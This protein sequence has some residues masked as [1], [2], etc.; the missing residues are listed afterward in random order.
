MIC[1]E[2][3]KCGQL[4]LAQGEAVGGY[5]YNAAYAVLD[6]PSRGSPGL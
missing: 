1:S 6:G 2:M 3:D 5:D 4:P